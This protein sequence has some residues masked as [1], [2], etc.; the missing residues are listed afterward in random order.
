M[1]S[2][3]LS[4]Y[5]FVLTIYFC[6]NLYFGASVFLYIVFCGAPSFGNCIDR[7]GSCDM[8]LCI[9]MIL[10]SYI[11]NVFYH[12][13]VCVFCVCVFVHFIFGAPSFGNC[14]DRQGSARGSRDL[15]NSHK[16]LS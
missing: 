6:I 14:I 7:Q 12:V 11:C 1:I 9:C 2:V 5:D 8:C 15:C 4:M 3:S 13:C 16:I 10:F